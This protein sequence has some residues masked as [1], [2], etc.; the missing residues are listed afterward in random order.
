MEEIAARE[1]RCGKYLQ[2]LYKVAHLAPSLKVAILE[3]KEPDS[4]TSRLLLQCELAI[5]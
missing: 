2:R 3:G 1:G 4:L 5:G